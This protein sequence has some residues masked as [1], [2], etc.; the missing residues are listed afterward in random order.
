ML[1]SIC[2]TLLLAGC[3]SPGGLFH[4]N[5]SFEASSVSALTAGTTVVGT[6]KAPLG[7]I[8]TGGGNVISTGGGNV[9]STGGGN[10]ISTGGG[11]FHTL[12]LEEQALIGAEVILCD[13][14]GLPIPGVLPGMTDAYG[15]YT[16]DNVPRGGTY[17]AVVRIKTDAGK[18]GEL[19]TIVKPVE[20][21]ATADITVGTTVVTTA[22]LV[23]RGR[24]MDTV[25]VEEFRNVVRQTEE[26]LKKGDMPDLGDPDS[27]MKK[28]REV[29]AEHESFK[30]MLEFRKDAKEAEKQAEKAEKPA[31][32]EEP[33]VK[34]EPQ[35]EP[36]YEQKE[37][38]DPP[39][40]ENTESDGTSGPSP[41][42][43][44]STPPTGGTSNSGTGI[45][46]VSPSQPPAEIEV[47]PEA[48]TPSDP[49]Q[50]EDPKNPKDPKKDHEDKD[51][52]KE[53]DKEKDK[54][55]DKK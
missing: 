18:A 38:D 37:E 16:L 23:T 11:N 32:L 7:V 40:S 48:T 43:E 8:S 19:R 9:I 13:A 6:V 42:P 22:V 28:A 36:N 25:T 12:A 54:D 29:A 27:L 35:A 34:K 21:T 30:Q 15:R 53:K 26:S 41:S 3:Q 17:V 2:L 44:A 31:K 49:T 51:K 39:P 24:D 20:A 4:P 14:A 52:D 10:V 1:G 33:K 46:D 50:A 45:G 47:T 5:L 55:K